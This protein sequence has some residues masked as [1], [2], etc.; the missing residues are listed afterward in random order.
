MK[1]GTIVRLPDGREGTVVY[2]SLIGEGIKWGR[3]NPDPEDFEGTDG[4]TVS[5]GAPDDWEWN[6][7]ALLREPW[8]GCERTGFTA[9]Q[10]VGADYEAVD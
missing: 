4:N 10:C 7:D 8:K 9:E 5:D 3:H 1:L 2:R 6:P